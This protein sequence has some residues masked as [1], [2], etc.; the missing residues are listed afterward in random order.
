[1]TWYRTGTAAFTNGNATVTGTGTA[2]IANASVGE[3]LI[4]PDGRIYEITAIASDTS[5]T[6]SP[7]YLGSTASGQAYAVA[8]IRGRIAQLLSETSSLLASFATV[9]D[10]IGSGLFPN[11]TVGA[12]ALRASADQDTGLFFPAAN[13]LAMVTGGAERVRVTS[14]GNVGIGTAAPVSYSG[15]STLTIQN[16]NGGAIN[17]RNGGAT[18]Q[19]EIAVTSAEAYMSTVSALPLTFK[20]TNIE[21]MRINASGNVGIGT[22]SPSVNL[23]IQG[24]ATSGRFNLK[25]NLAQG[26]ELTGGAAGVDIRTANVLPITFATSG[27]ERMR[28]DSSG[29]VGIGTSSP[30]DPLH[31]AGDIRNANAAYIVQETSTGSAVRVLGINASNVCYVGAVDSG[32]A[33]TIFNAS[34]TSAVSA[35]YTSGTE[36]MR[37]DSSGNVGIGTAAPSAK[38]HISDVS[39]PSLLIQDTTNNVQLIAQALDTFSILGNGT[40][41]PLTFRTSN[42]ERLRVDTAGTVRPGADNTQSLGEASYRWSTVFAGTGTINTS[43]EREKVWR[44]AMTEPE[45]RAAKRLLGELGMFQF[46][47]SVEEKGEDA[48]LHFGVRAQRAFAILEDEG[49]EWWRYAWCCHDEWD[50]I[51]EPVMEEVTVEKTRTVEVPEEREV[52]KTET[53]MEPVLDEETGEQVLDEAGQPVMAEIEQTFTVTETVMVEIEET[54]EETE[55]RDTGEVRVVR[56]AGDRYGIRADQLAYWL[57]AAQAEIQ[58]DLDARLAALESQQA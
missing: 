42:T 28:I 37:I 36:R 55:Q 50:E 19:A 57:I 44:G 21:R 29:N 34:P 5:L 43:D 46:T 16:T 54:Y 35:F 47:D 22:T 2:W 48:R 31:V 24:D 15:Y 18:A 14:A 51:T 26:L 4:A 25:N 32:V 33:S 45:M 58:A 27:T 3:G 12:P 11:G 17:L 52:E 8:P 13:T 40:A 49:L 39:S 38:L 6:I 10:G 1:M 23:Q 41:H 7:A 9:R 30:L 20:T 53:V 56:E